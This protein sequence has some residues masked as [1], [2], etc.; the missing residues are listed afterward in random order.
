LLESG[1]LRNVRRQDF[2][3]HFPIV[4]RVIR[5]KYLAH[6]PFTDRFEQAVGPK[7]RFH[8]ALHIRRART[9]ES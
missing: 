2:Q 7:I 8:L 9:R 1:F 6:P 3:R 5:P 4:H